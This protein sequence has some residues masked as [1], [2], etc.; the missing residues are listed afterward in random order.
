MGVGD[1]R[2]APAASLHGERPGTNCKGGWVGPEPVWTDVEN[3]TITGFRSPDR[4][5]RVDLLYRLRCL[6]PQNH[7]LAKLNYIAW[8][9]A[10]F[11]NLSFFYSLPVK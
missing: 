8:Q 9:N 4:P 10:E 7:T 3:P 2:H 5:V 11:L 6:G 1:Q